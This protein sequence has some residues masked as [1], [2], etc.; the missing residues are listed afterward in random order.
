M[1]RYTG[2]K[3]RLCRREGEKLFLRGSRCE[4]QKCAITR[5]NYKPGQ[6]AK[7]TF[8]KITE[9]AKQLRAKQKARRI[10]GISEKQFSIYCT[11][12]MK[13]KEETGMALLKSLETRLDNAMYRSGFAESRNQ[14]RQ[15]VNHGVVKLNGKRVDIPSIH[16]KIG[17]TFEV[18]EKLK[19][20][21]IFEK[22]KANKKFKSSKWL[23]ADSQTLKCEVINMPDKDDVEAS[24]ETQLVIEFYSK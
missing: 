22:V 9:Y 4:G 1:S 10:Y 17:D 14:A 21:P 12:A 6:V 19:T 3:C 8:G 13:K 24:I 20:S 18:R 16:L 7:N 23:K 15:F 2:A 5:R 11:E